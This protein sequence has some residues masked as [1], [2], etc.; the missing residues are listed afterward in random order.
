MPLS[1]SAT[2]NS[3]AACT[4]FIGCGVIITSDRRMPRGKLYAAAGYK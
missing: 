2:F 4:M 3:F 1:D